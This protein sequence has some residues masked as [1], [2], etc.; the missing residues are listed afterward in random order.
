M[1]TELP[2]IIAKGENPVVEFKCDS[3]CPEQLAKVVVV[4]ANLKVSI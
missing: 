1:L 2:E 4:K 3:P